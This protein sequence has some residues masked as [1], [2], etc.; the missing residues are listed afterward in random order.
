V[1]FTRPFGHWLKQRRQTLDLTQDGL[2]RLIGYASITLRQVEAGTRRPSRQ[3]AE[4][5]ADHLHIPASDHAAFIAFARGAEYPRW[6][7]PLPANPMIG[8]A[9][10]TRQARELLARDDVRL[11]NLVGPPGVG[12]TRLALEVARQASDAF[13]DGGCF[14]GLAPI[15]DPGLV[16]STITEAMQIRRA[17]DRPVEE[18]LVSYLSDKQLLLL[19]DNFEHL[20]PAA[21][22]VATLLTHAPGLKVL[23]TS[24][25]LLHLTGEHVFE[26]APLAAPEPGYRQSV[27]SLLTYPAVEL[28]VERA[29]QA[30][31]S[32]ALTE[33]N[34]RAVTELCCNLDG[35]PLAIELAAARIRAFTPQTILTRLDHHAGAKLQFLATGA[36]DLPSRQLA[37]R[38]TLDWSYDLLSSDEQAVFRQLSVFAGGCALEA[39]ESICDPEVMPGQPSAVDRGQTHDIARLIELLVEKSLVQEVAGAAGE[40]RYTMLETIR[41]YALERLEASG[42]ADAVRRRHARYFAMK[43][44]MDMDSP[45]WPVVCTGLLKGFVGEGD[46]LY[47]SLNWSRGCADEPLLHLLISTVVGWMVHVGGWCWGTRGDIGAIRSELVW[48]LERNPDCSPTLRAISL[49]VLGLLWLGLGDL[50]QAARVLDESLALSLGTGAQGIAASALHVRGHCAYLM[51][52]LTLAESF[53]TRHLEMGIQINAPGWMLNGLSM[54]G[55]VALER[56]DLSRSTELLERA[57]PLARSLGIKTDIL[58]GQAVILQDIGVVAYEQGDYARAYALGSQALSL[59]EEG[60][61]MLRRYTQNLYLGRVTLTQQRTGV[62]EQHLM[63][64]LRIARE[65]GLRP[66]HAVVQLAQAAAQWGDTMRYARLMGIAS[67]WFPGNQPWGGVSKHEHDRC[68]SAV[69]EA[70]AHLG[71]P[72]FAAAW[73]MGQAMTLDQAVAYAL[74]E[75]EADVPPEEPAR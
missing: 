39:A 71:E 70:Q 37:L 49:Q 62:A 36:R 72:A 47:A 25:A 33:S 50:G 75:D 17:H 59:I 12:K 55:H 65:Y 22:L 69:E 26:V 28:F 10:D 64:S 48:S 52:E 67:Q 45:A 31:P 1:E 14:V 41:E 53:F 44:V 4:L 2:A 66:R 57:L 51:S 46:N 35:L 63:E 56:G 24:R 23:V 27:R 3:V 40:S 19:L 29:Q 18:T 5:L 34:A 8:R 16:S 6:H 13:A 58:G 15:S 21:P 74:R 7:L 38:A 20:T 61:E 43:C 60:G 54:L 73:A 30:K 9:E 68:L 32:F 42:E 11:L